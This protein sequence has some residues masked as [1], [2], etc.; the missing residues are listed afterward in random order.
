MTEHPLIEFVDGPKDGE[1]ERIAPFNY[2]CAAPGGG[3]YR[4]E[5]IEG[6]DV[7]KFWP[8]LTLDE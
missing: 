4:R 3:L 6:R 2:L 8:N 1:W 5:I 7:M